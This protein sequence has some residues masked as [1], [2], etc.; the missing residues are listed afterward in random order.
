MQSSRFIKTGKHRA[1]STDEE[2]ADD[3]LAD[4][5]ELAGEED[6]QSGDPRWDALKGLSF[7]EDN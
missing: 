2:D 1:V 4:D 3:E 5:E 7:F 6:P